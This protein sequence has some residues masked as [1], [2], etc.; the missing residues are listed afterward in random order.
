MTIWLHLTTALLAREPRKAVGNGIAMRNSISG[1]DVG[2]R[3]NQ[4]RHL[5]TE[6]HLDFRHPAADFEG[7]P[8]CPVVAFPHAG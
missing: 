5:G 8:G 7:E 4:T 3:G 1:L 2:L 6:I